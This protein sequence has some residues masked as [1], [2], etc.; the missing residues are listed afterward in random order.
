MYH[1]WYSILNKHNYYLIV[2]NGT[3]FLI[4]LLKLFIALLKTILIKVWL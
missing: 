2:A 4:R 3:E 1:I